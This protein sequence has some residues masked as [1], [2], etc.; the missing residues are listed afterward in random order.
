MTTPKTPDKID[1]REKFIELFQQ[2]EDSLNGQKSSAGH[3]IQKTA[4][5]RFSDDLYFPTKRNEDWKY[6]NVAQLLQ[7]LYLQPKRVD[8]AAEDINPFLFEGLDAYVLVFVNG[9]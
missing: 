2:Y 8:I 5:Q 1:S 7:P 6:T 4:I 9:T 3:S